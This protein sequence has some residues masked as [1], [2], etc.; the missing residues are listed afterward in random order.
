MSLRLDTYMDAYV[1]LSNEN[2][3]VHKIL[4]DLKGGGG[5]AVGSFRLD[6]ENFLAGSF[7]GLPAQCPKHTAHTLY[8]YN[9]Q[10]SKG[11]LK[12]KALKSAISA[13]LPIRASFR[14]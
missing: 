6:L 5:P 12:A 1:V 13:L 3:N 8:R 9:L 4:V 10:F 7:A 11:L 14:M 2:E